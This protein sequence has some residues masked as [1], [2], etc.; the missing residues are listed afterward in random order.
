MILFTS[1]SDEATAWRKRSEAANSENKHV[2]DLQVHQ[3]LCCGY[4]FFFTLWRYRT[5]ISL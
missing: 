5:Q 4:Q 3:L 2:S 1:S